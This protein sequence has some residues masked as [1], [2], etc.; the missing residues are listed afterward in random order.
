M[1]WATTTVSPRWS[2]NARLE[3]RRA[4]AIAE[5]DARVGEERDGAEPQPVAWCGAQCC[6]LGVQGIGGAVVAGVHERQHVSRPPREWRLALVEEALDQSEELGDAPLRQAQ[7]EQLG[8]RG[9]GEVGAGVCAD[10]RVG[11]CVLSLVQTSL[12]EERADVPHRRER[13]EEWTAAL[14]GPLVKLGGVRRGLGIASEL[15]QGRRSPVARLDHDV[16]PGELLAER[17]RLVDIVRRESASSGPQLTSTHVASAIVSARGS[18]SRRASETAVAACDLLRRSSWG[19]V[20]A[21]PASSST[22][23]GLSAGT[24]RRARANSSTVSLS[25]MA[26]SVANASPHAAS[27]SSAMSPIATAERAARRNIVNASVNS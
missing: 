13:D 11:Q 9:L 20:R 8:R 16:D 21:S 5:G 1:P 15:E 22:R 6:D 4:R 24:V 12:V 26:N 14:A 23:R 3:D 19:I 7:Q 25:A 27:L 17:D 18:P 10:W 2:C